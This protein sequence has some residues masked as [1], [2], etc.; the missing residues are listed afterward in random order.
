[1]K[2]WYLQKMVI[3]VFLPVA[4]S[5]E[6]CKCHA[7]IR[8]RHELLALCKLE[9]T[10]HNEHLTNAGRAGAATKKMAKVK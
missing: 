7:E 3:H 9:L 5:A 4:T 10:V 6:R 8:P 1:M 2:H